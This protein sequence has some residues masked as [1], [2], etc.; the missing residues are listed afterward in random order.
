MHLKSPYPESQIPMRSVS[1]T[2]IATF[3]ISGK[4]EHPA[5]SV[6]LNSSN[7]IGVILGPG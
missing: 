4:Q 3:P 5:L 2:F 6:F 1:G 7:G